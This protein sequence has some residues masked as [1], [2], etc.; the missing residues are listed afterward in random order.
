MEG[1]TRLQALRHDLENASR[2]PSRQEAEEFQFVLGALICFTAGGVLR[3]SSVSGLFVLQT[4]EDGATQVASIRAAG[5]ANGALTMAI[6][7]ELSSTYILRL[8][9]FKNQGAYLPNER[10]EF[11]LAKP[12]S[13]LLNFF[14][15]VVRSHLS[16]LPSNTFA[17]V[18]HTDSRAGSWFESSRD[19]FGRLCGG[20]G[21]L[22]L[23][24]SVQV[25][26][27]LVSTEAMR[28]RLT[29]LD[30]ADIEAANLHSLEV[31]DRYYVSPVVR[32][33]EEGASSR[34]QGT[35]RLLRGLG[36]GTPLCS[37]IPLKLAVLVTSL[38]SV[39]MVYGSVS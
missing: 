21:G 38:S 36:K 15:H 35:G 30:R 29:P 26:R 28:Q 7:H 1:L 31:A 17:F 14:V 12:V 5:Y 39:C 33:D 3:P 24:V 16:P 11:V 34:H 18:K 13:S 9:A 2:P 19:G 20:D 25:I 4:S 27:H 23:G 6:Y 22:D 32:A 37:R 8:I 10:L